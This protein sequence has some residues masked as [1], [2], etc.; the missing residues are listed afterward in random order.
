[1]DTPDESN[2]QGRTL[3]TTSYAV[4]SVLSVRDHATYDLIRQMR[5]SMHYMWP[6]AESNVYAEPPRLVAAGLA[7]AHEEWTGQRRRTVYAITAAGRT[8]LRAWL[9]TPSAPP[10]YECEPLVKTLFAE[11]GT[12]DDLLAAIRELAEEARA[13][14]RHFLAI[15]DEYAAGDGEYPWRFGL[16]GLTARLL[17]EQDAATLRWAAWAAQVVSGWEDPLAPPAEWGVATIR[18]TGTPFPI[19]DDPVRD[20]VE[21]AGGGDGHPPS[22]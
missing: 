2:S 5:K 12:R 10:R 8:A 13:A 4:L 22:G 3:T 7:T 15:A 21:A 9:A 1:M 19:G 14:M 11:N 20:V 17:L 18:A 16:S 6:R